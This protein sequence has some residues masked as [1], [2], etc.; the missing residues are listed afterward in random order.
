MSSH[1]TTRKSKGAGK[2]TY[3]CPAI[4]YDYIS[5]IH[6]AVNASGAESRC[7]FHSTKPSEAECLKLQPDERARAESIDQEFMN[8]FRELCWKCEQDP[9]CLEISCVGFRFPAIAF[10]RR[11]SKPV[12]FSFAVFNGIDL[13]PGVL[14][15]AGMFSHLLAEDF[16]GES[17]ASDAAR[18]SAQDVQFLGTVF[19]GPAIFSYAA[20]GDVD[21]TSAQFL[22]DAYFDNTG[23]EKGCNF[24]STVFA[25]RVS[26]V[27]ATFA[28]GVTFRGTRFI[29]K[30]MAMETPGSVAID[31]R[32]K[33]S[34]FFMS[35]DVDF[36]RTSF[37]QTAE[38]IGASFE[39]RTSFSSARFARA[40]FHQCTMNGVAEFRQTAF[41]ERISVTA[42][43][44]AGSLFFSECYFPEECSF[45]NLA[46]LPQSNVTYE[47]CS[48]NYASF[49]GTELESIQFRD[50]SW[51]KPSARGIRPRRRA[52]LWGEV[53]PLTSGQKQRDYERLAE[54]YRQLVL[55]YE[56]K[57][58]SELAEEFHIGEMEMR[59]KQA[60]AALY[61]AGRP[62]LAW[63]R[64]QWNLYFVYRLA[65]NYGTSYW[66]ASLVLCT[67]I[68]LFSLV[69]MH[70]GFQPS[71]DAIGATP[72]IINY[73]MLPGA[74]VVWRHQSEWLADFGESLLYTLSIIS[75]QR[76]RFYEP[77]GWQGRLALFAAV[78]S[79][80]A[81]VAVVLLAIRRRF[82]R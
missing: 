76:E 39:G 70:A 16:D 4:G 15:S 19:K 41:E 67:L 11:F 78:P 56:A 42:S 61:D 53:G 3:H 52:C 57:R 27:D 38:F 58:N 72:R 44:I 1:H 37:A 73:S 26:F 69:F 62:H 71:R 45:E 18:A 21:F 10:N 32:Y 63:L 7:L 8:A 17:P 54:A 59:R 50:V 43:L 66:Q 75:F 48:L 24:T 2:C 77:V 30:A 35:E 79:I 6:P 46:L 80:T 65:S 51:A 40:L 9:T 13:M 31:L 74:D 33:D 23:F 68:L 20:L 64:T 14:N 55:N 36:H 5:C 34:S 25:G 47:T 60:G 81:Q 28:E 82:R 12:N 49:E 22:A 29:R